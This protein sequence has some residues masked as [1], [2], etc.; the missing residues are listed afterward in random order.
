MAEALNEKPKCCFSDT[1]PWFWGSLKDGCQFS[2]ET[3]LFEVDDKKYCRFHM[4]VVNQAGRPTPKALWDAA[5]NEIFKDGITQLLDMAMNNR[6]PENIFFDSVVDLSGV[7]FPDSFDFTAWAR[8]QAGS[9]PDYAKSGE[10]PSEGYLL[11]N[12]Y[13]NTARFLKGANLSDL[14]FDGA[15]SFAFATF[16]ASVSFQRTAFKGFYTSFAG[17]RFADRVD[18]SASDKT[19]PFQ[20]IDFRFVKFAAEYPCKEVCYNPPEVLFINRKF[21]D[22]ADFTGSVFNVAPEFYGAKFHQGCNIG[23]ATF[24]QTRL[25]NSPPAYRVLKVAMEE[26]R[27]WDAMAKFHALELSSIHNQPNTARPVKIVSWAYD[28]ASEYGQSFL[29]PLI[30]IF[31]VAFVWFLLYCFVLGLAGIKGDVSLLA[32]VFK[33]DLMQMVLPFEAFV[34]KEPEKDPILSCLG[35]VWY[36]LVITLAFL[37]TLA[38]AG[39]VTLFILAVRRRFRMA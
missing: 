38:T 1:K 16:G 21:A 33:F 27:D 6:D 20:R 4:P 3:D 9:S 19:L 11:P 15:I 34:Q 36:G 39:F 26:S 32:E 2:N 25:P 17:V 28:M 7:I 37:Q 5:Q 10:E 12:I 13:A 18:F 23:A 29:R 30:G 24:K 14:V 8:S 35:G 22:K 31:A